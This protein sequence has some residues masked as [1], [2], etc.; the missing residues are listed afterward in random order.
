M[1]FVS[2]IVFTMVGGVL[3]G[4]IA[5]AVSRIFYI[6]ILSP[7][8]TGLLA[9]AFIL[10]AVQR[11]KVRFPLLAAFFG[12]VTG[13]LTFTTFQYG[14]YI[15]F[16][17]DLRLEAS[18]VLI[19]QQG[20]AS[21][22]DVEQ[23][24]ER[25]LQRETGSRGFWA[26]LLF[27]NNW[28]TWAL[29]L[30][31]ISAVVAYIGFVAARRPFC[32]TCDNWYGPEQHLGG[33]PADYKPTLLDQLNNHLLTPIPA[34]LVADPPRPSVDLFLKS[35]L[36]C[37]TSDSVLSATEYRLNWRGGS[38]MKQLFQGVVSPHERATLLQKQEGQ[39]QTHL[40]RA[41]ALEE[42]GRYADALAA[43]S[44][45]LEFIPRS[46]EAHNLRGLLLDEL[47][48]KK[49][50]IAAYREA[51]RLDPDFREARENLAEAE[52]GN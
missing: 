28:L 21:A 47:G 7:I 44:Q 27:Q 15:N 17:N 10:A 32:N 48:R 22:A 1:G 20:E 50:A 3:A 40:D 36:T 39:G 11:G 24:V 4:V 46:A 41:Y 43:C 5:Y 18:E 30:I 26:Y 16:L 14:H 42:E 23:L 52:T 13:F 45:A 8:A 38:K 9:G 25:Y 31:L 33:V 35:C 12:L 37:E 2:L 6:P 34:M 29:E 51:L 19:E 49:E